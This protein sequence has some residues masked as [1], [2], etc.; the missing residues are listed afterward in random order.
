M[1]PDRVTSGPSCTYGLD[2]F[3][4]LNGHKEFPGQIETLFALDVSPESL[5]KSN[6]PL[7]E[8]NGL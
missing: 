8:S 3:P 5:R 4:G 7:P 2:A 1:V 6:V